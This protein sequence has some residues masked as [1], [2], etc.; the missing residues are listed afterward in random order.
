MALISLFI[1]LE[2]KLDMFFIKSQIQLEPDRSNSSCSS[3]NSNQIDPTRAVLHQTR[4]RSIYIALIS[5]QIRS[6]NQIDLSC[7]VSQAPEEL[8]K[9][10][11]LFFA[12]AAENWDVAKDKRLF[13][14]NGEQ[15][16]SAFLLVGLGIV[17][18]PNYNCIIS[19][20]IFSSRNDLLAYEEAIEVTNNGSPI[21]EN[22]NESV[23]RCIELSARVSNS[24]S[25]ATQSSTSE[26]LVTC[27]SCFSALWVYSKGVLLGVSFLECERS[28]LEAID[29]I[30]QGVQNLVV[31]IK[32]NSRKAQ[33][34]P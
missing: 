11:K 4:T 17:K 10:T 14:L 1:E 15:D 32:S 20:Q 25:G 13:F 12:H 9:K 8:P 24:S 22:N 5:D 29:L 30:L 26:S 27:F 3:S 31:P 6:L 33:D 18:Y 21:D 23:L 19:N 34:S 28:L 7:S 16:L 2:L